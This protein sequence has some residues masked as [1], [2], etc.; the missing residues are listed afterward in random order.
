MRVCEHVCVCVCVCVCAH[1][2]IITFF[3]I[4][5]KLIYIT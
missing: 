3:L 2:K 4:K 1:N 5:E